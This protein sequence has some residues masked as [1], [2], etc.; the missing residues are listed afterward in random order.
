MPRSVFSPFPFKDVELDMNEAVIDGVIDWPLVFLLVGSSKYTGECGLPIGDGSFLRD[1][2]LW[3]S[4]TGLV[5]AKSPVMER[6]VLPCGIRHL[7]ISE[8]PVAVHI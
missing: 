1:I 3:V 2:G 8:L 7:V 6:T 5:I 4:D